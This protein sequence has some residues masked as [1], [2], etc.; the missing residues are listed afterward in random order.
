MKLIN[1][2]SKNILVADLE[3]ASNFLSRGKGLLGRSH[4]AESA[5]LW[6]LNCKDIHTCFMKFP[7]DAIFLDENMKVIS[8]HKNIQPWRFTFSWKAKS[9]IELPAGKILAEKIQ[10]GDHLDVVD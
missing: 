8:L 6:I 5:G 10:I 7:I 1:Q 3:K 9:V 4:L 2:S